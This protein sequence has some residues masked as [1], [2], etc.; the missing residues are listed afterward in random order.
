MTCSGVLLR[1]YNS[2]LERVFPSGIPFAWDFRLLVSGREKWKETA[3]S[4]LLFAESAER[5][6]YINIAQLYLT[7]LSGSY[8]EEEMADLLKRVSATSVK[9]LPDLCQQDE[10]KN[11][12][13]A[14]RKTVKGASKS[15]AKLSRLRSGKKY[16]VR[17]RTYRSYNGGTLYSG[18]SRLKSKKTK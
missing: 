15:K 7:L 6:G 2:K 13:E 17:I 18:W 4:L 3:R 8:A 1:K 16:Y 10:W 11:M 12:L 5:A 14:M 9:F